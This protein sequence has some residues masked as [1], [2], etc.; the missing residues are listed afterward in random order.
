M[1]VRHSEPQLK[2]HNLGLDHDLPWLLQRRG[3]L[4]L[5]TRD[6]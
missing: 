4:K 2:N 1:G 6:W 3:P 5:V